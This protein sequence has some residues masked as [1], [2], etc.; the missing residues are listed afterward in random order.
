PDVQHHLHRRRF[1]D[2]LRPDGRI[3]LLMR[4]RIVAAILLAACAALALGAA[5]AARGAGVAATGPDEALFRLVNGAAANPVL[6]VV[7][8]VATDL[9]RWRVLFLLVW[10]ALVIFGG[11]KGR[12]AALGLILLVAASDQLSSNLLKPLVARAR[13]CE[14]LGGVRMWRGDAGWIETPLEVTRSWKSSFAFPSSHAANITA[15][16]FFLAALYRRA[17]WWLVGV[18]VLVSLSRVYVGVHWPSDVLFGMALGAALAWGAVSL[19]H[20]MAPPAPAT[21]TGPPGDADGPA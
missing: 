18:A 9:D 8:P 1:L 21:R 5:L 3:L 10:A 16:M 19:H 20:R 13:P 12:W 2:L 14:I 7:M 6:D 15:T 4:P 17:R 11:A